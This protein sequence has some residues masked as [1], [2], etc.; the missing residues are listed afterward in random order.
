ML[1][2]YFDVLSILILFFII[3]LSLSSLFCINDINN[4][5]DINNIISFIQ[6]N[7]TQSEA[8]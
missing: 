8:S 4:D 7:T 1:F 2:Y 6:Y 3:F 5:F